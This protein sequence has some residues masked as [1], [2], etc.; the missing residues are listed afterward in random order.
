MMRLGLLYK[1]LG[2]TEGARWLFQHVSDHDPRNE[3]ARHLLREL[4]TAP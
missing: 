2:V 3:N 1:E 4:E